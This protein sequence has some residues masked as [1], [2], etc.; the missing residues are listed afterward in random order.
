M[1]SDD[2]KKG[3]NF[4]LRQT[5]LEFSER[6]GQRASSGLYASV[7]TKSVEELIKDAEIILRYL[8]KNVGDE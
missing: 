8:I 6:C 1:D 2:V 4:M 5:A 7:G 3:K